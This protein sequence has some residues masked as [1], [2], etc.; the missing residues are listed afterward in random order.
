MPINDSSNNLP[1]V[2]AT[3]PSILPT[4]NGHDEVTRQNLARI[5]KVLKENK[6]DENLF[7]ILVVV[8]F[9]AGI[10]LLVS[11]TFFQNLGLAI[12]PV[13]TT[14]FL[15]Y[16]LDKLEKLRKENKALAIVPALTTSMN[17]KDATKEIQRLLQNLYDQKDG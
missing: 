15:K 13:I 12:P 3:E 8:L 11:A 14:F 7:K 1:V 6:A 16:P 5:D 9:L 4:A 17:Q 10:I 2:I